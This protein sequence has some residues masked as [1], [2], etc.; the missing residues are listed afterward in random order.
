VTTTSLSLLERA[1]SDPESDEWRRLTAIY[2]PLLRDWLRR[3][4]VQE[5][6]ADD[7]IQEVL[8][9]IAR[10]LP[11]FEH[12]GNP[13]AF[14]TWLK[15]ILVYRLLNYWRSRNAHPVES[16]G[17]RV[18][19]QIHELAD[20]ASG[21][22]GLWDAEHDRHVLSKLL[23]QVRPRFQ[24]QTWDAF[25]RVMFDGESPDAVAAALGLAVHSVYVA[26]SRVLQALRQ[27]AAG[28][29]DS[30]HTERADPEATAEFPPPP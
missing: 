8:L 13:G 14:R 18:M 10:E 28:L 17:S 20:P 16:G 12:S 21:L 27:E 3:Y 1:R 30:V 9:T 6:D 19:D 15:T 4:S 5:S 24:P 22:S 7:L 2:S 29:V 26:K 23:Q 11:A 25:H